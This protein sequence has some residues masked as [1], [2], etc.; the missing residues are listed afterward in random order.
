MHFS[1][2]GG[3]RIESFGHPGG[4]ARLVG[5]DLVLLNLLQFLVLNGSNGRST[6]PLLHVR[7]TRL[8]DFTQL[9]ILVASRLAHELKI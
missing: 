7:L 8:A 1:R 6:R 2:L 4:P 3:V 5:C 9:I